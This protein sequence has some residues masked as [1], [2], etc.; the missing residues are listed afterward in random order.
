MLGRIDLRTNPPAEP[1]FVGFNGIPSRLDVDNSDS[2]TSITFNSTGDY[3][4]VTLQGNN[5]VAAFD[6]LAVRN[7][8]GQSSVWRSLS[9]A[10]PQASLYDP[11]HQALWVKNFMSRDLTRLELAEFFNSGTIQL[12][13]QTVSTTLNE[14][15]SADVLAGKQR[16]YFAGNNPVG[17][18]DMSFEGYIS[19]AGCH[20]DGSHDG[21]VWDFSGKSAEICPI[22]W[23][24]PK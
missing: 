11:A 17:Q 9:G 22:D 4:F 24:G 2:P 19:C 18:N 15:L 20:I 21:R 16:F 6:D 8:V 14:A 7:N 23:H 13:P 3:V 12:N 1:E 5:T 10:A